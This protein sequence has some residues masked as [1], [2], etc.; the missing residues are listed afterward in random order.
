M[1]TITGTFCDASANP[2]RT[3]KISNDIRITAKKDLFKKTPP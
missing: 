3:A 2:E 1:E